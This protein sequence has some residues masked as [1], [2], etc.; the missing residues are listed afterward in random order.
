MPFVLDSSATIPCFAPDE[1]PI[2][3]VE[4]R[5]LADSVMVP[6]IW[7]Q[8]IFNV[9]CMMERRRRITAAQASDIASGL[10]QLTV[11]IEPANL[12][13]IA[14]DVYPLAKTHGLTIYDAS[15]LE[16]AL[17]RQLPLA[18]LD[19]ALMRAAKK[20]KVKLI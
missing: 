12:Q 17:R 14:E 2:P 9:L 16:L 20:A 6:A 13:R 5:L 11:A 15:Y 10:Q 8:E 1:L 4:K 18:T 19:E 7:P 3:A